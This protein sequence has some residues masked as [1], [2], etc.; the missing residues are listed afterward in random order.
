M[1]R[2]YYPHSRADKFSQS[3]W[4]L[5]ERKYLSGKKFQREYTVLMRIPLMRSRRKRCGRYQRQRAFACSLSFYNTVETEPPARR[6]SHFRFSNRPRNSP[7]RFCTELQTSSHVSSPSKA[8]SLLL[9]GDHF[10][11][12]HQAIRIARKCTVLLELLLGR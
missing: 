7:A 1:R 3:S 10:D 11:V 5:I 4:R 9:S 2:P 8:V 6:Y 12:M